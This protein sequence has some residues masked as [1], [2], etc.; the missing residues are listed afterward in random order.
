MKTTDVR[1]NRPLSNGGQ[2]DQK[3]FSFYKIIAA[4]IGRVG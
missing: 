4:K 1:G 2:L 3:T